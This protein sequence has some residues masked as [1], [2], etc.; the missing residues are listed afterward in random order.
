MTRRPYR[1]TG[2]EKCIHVNRV[3]AKLGSAKKLC[4]KLVNGEI[5]HIVENK[6]IHRSPFVSKEL[7][8]NNVKKET[9]TLF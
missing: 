8:E 3:F 1:V 2:L 9:T 6:I 5:Y 7:K 4:D